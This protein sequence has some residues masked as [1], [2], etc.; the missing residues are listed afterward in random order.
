MIGYEKDTGGLVL[1][2]SVTLFDTDRHFIITGTSSYGVENNLNMFRKIS[3]TFKLR[4]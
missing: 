2:Y 1:K 4:K 3:K